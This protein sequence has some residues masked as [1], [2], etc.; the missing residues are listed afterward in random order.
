MRII[1]VGC[2]KVGSA[3]AEQLS[4]EGHDLTLVDLSAKRLDELT[5]SLD[6]SSVTG[7]GT[8]F[9][10][11][12]EAGVKTADLL[13]AVTTQDEINLLACMIARK[14]SGCHT[15]ARVRN[16]EYASEVGFIRDELGLS[17]VINP[18]L[19][20][21]R[22]VSRLIRFPS[23]IRVST[24]AKGRIEL[25][26]IHVPDD[27]RLNG[28]AVCEVSHLL[29]CNVLMCMV[30]RAGQTFIPKGDFILEKG[31]DIT[32]IIPPREQAYFFEQVGIPNDHI[33]SAMLIGGGKI[34]FFLAGMLL[35]A[36]I[37]VK[38]IETRLDR[39]EQLSELLP[40]ATIIY[41]DGT[42]RSLLDEEGL[43]TCEA[44][45]ALTGMDEE[46]ILLALHAK[47][48]SHARVFT[49]INRVNFEE[50]IAGLPLG[51]VVRPK[52]TTADLI[53][54][55]IR[56]MQNSLGSNVET[57]H[58]LHGA[59]ALEFRVG[60]NHLTGVP[61]Q[62][63]PIRPDVLLCCINRHGKRI[64]PRGQ[65]MLKEGD[66]VIVVSTHAGMT[67]LGDIFLKQDETGAVTK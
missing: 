10:V 55:Y 50:V 47:Q 45:V 1:I 44:F 5:N 7:S 66:T 53:S 9:R 32:V 38:I 25:L 8:N 20:T 65:D 3:L 48:H 2:G 64:I 51:T 6:V 21:A 63:M 17:M 40:G 35:D 43:G 18:E 67:D 12:K 61:L 11:L 15:I 37:A 41:G 58:Q 29:R 27:S 23:A 34:S 31:D 4:A 13:I 56:A 46:N 52:Q 54:Q 57:L 33:G 59:E 36:G 28:M 62:D 16:P 60:T 30:H 26:E 24:F 22:A 42:D 19:S 49:K 14:A 39:C